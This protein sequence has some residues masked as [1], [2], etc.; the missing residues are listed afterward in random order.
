[1]ETLK[2]LINKEGSGV[3][4]SLPD[5]DGFVIAS[6]SVLSLK[7]ELLESLKFHIEGLCPDK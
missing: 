3:S 1:M 4:A 6:S 7:K 2:V 5:L